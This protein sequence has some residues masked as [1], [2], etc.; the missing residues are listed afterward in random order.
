ME[1]AVLL[2]TRVHVPMNRR[3]FLRVAAATGLTIGPLRLWAVP[4]AAAKTKIVIVLLRGGYDAASLLVPYNSAFYYE[5]RPNIAIARPVN[6]HPDTALALDSYWAL[7]PA[8]KD[9]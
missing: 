4:E 5:S 7:H 2:L 9:S 3:S 6:S 1:C 8:L